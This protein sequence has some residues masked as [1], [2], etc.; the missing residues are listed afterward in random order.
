MHIGACRKRRYA[1]ILNKKKLPPFFLNIKIYIPAF[2]PHE[3][4]VCKR[5]KKRREGR[6]KICGAFHG[7]FLETP[8]S[9]LFPAIPTEVPERMRRKTALFL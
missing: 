3:T 7:R 5:H 9:M 1:F 8:E 2:R 4:P 6:A